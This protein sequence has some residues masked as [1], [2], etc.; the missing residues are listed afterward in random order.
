MDSTARRIALRLG[1]ALVG[2]TLGITGLAGAYSYWQSYYQHRGFK[3]VALARG[4]KRGQLLKVE[5]PSKALGHTSDYLIYLPPGYRRTGHYPVYYLLHGSPGR[6]SVY[7][8]IVSIGIRMDNL[9]AEHRMRPMI[10]VFP[11]GRIGG[12]VFSDSE[13]ANTPSG[14]Y[15]GYVLDVVANVDHGFATIPNR[16]HRVIAGFSAGAYGATN[17]ALHHLDVFGSFQSWSGYYRQSK[18][19]VFARAIPSQLADNSPLTFVRT[20]GPQLATHPVR[21]FLFTGRDDNSSP[22]TAPM[23]GALA[24]RGAQVS[25][26]LYRGGHDWQLWAAHVNQMLRLASRDV[27]LPLTRGNGRAHTL[28]PGVVPLPHGRGRHRHGRRRAVHTRPRRHDRR[29][30][31]QARLAPLPSPA[32]PLLSAGLTPV[33]APRLHRPPRGARLLLGLMLALVS[34]AL[35]N[36]GFLLQHRGLGETGADGL[37]ASL[38]RAW[39]NPTWLGGQLVGWI[40]FGAQIVAVAIAPLSL[41]QSFAAGGLAISVPLAAW[42]FAHRVSRRQVGAVLLIAAGLA[43]LPIGFGTGRDHLHESVLMLAAGLATATALGL[44]AGRRPVLAAL[45]AG[46]FYGVADAAIKAVSVDWSAHGASAVLSGWTVAA[47]LATFGGFLAFQAALNRGSAI[48]GISLMT[49]LS[50]LVALACGTVA[51]AESLGTNALAVIAHLIAIAVV[52]GCVPVLARAQAEMARA[53]QPPTGVP[54]HPALTY[55]PSR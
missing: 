24:A 51:F 37:A 2:L 36:L 31:R 43:V 15:E 22:Q 5:F 23:A 9:I 39:R 25:Y 41:V 53:P 29:P 52:L 20:L 7:L 48:T 8:A 1:L 21:A 55:E 32:G 19:G 17:I 46:I 28:T 49:A 13:W 4:A 27:T 12:S 16:A 42:L 11:D 40:G 38:R 18:T 14:D 44:A 54:G 6:P 35:I 50:A 26:A 47:A 30:R 10:L 3:P 45:A 34:A 33:A